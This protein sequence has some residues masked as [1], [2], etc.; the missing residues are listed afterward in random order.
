MENFESA[1]GGDY[2]ELSWSKARYLQAPAPVRMEW[3]SETNWYKWVSTEVIEDSLMRSLSEAEEAMSVSDLADETGETKVKIRK[4]VAKLL[5][6][7]KIKKLPS[8]ATGEGSTGPRYR[9][10]S[11]E[12][13]NSNG[14]LSL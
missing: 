12:N 6:E 8:I 11:G 3:D 13:D 10:P 5:D 14:G 4:I 1:R 2:R 9:V 7:K